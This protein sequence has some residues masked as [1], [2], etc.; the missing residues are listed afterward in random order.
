[1]KI[2]NPI[3]FYM[4][5][6]YHTTIE[7]V[8]EDDNIYYFVARHPELPG[9]AAD[10]ESPQ[11]AVANLRSAKIDYIN[12]LLEWGDEVPLPNISVRVLLAKP[13]PFGHPVVLQRFFDRKAA[14]SAIDNTPRYFLEGRV[15]C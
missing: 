10:G 14:P 15:C 8:T 1:M 12:A 7:R 5:K 9:C 13:S 11:E 3:S 4:K 2:Q 6:T